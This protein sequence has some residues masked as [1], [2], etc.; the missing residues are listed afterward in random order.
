MANSTN[1]AGVSFAP[2]S[3][4]SSCRLRFLQD[5]SSQTNLFGYTDAPHDRTTGDIT[6]ATISFYPNAVLTDGT[7]TQ[8][9]YDPSAPGYDTIYQRVAVHE[10][11]H[12]M[13]LE[14]PAPDPSNPCHVQMPGG[15]VMNTFRGTNDQ[16]NNVP[17][18]PTPCDNDVVKNQVYGSQTANGSSGGS[19]SSPSSYFCTYFYTYD[20][21]YRCSEGTCYE[22]YTVYWYTGSS[23]N[24]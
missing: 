1:G 22:Q 3:S 23:C 2:A 19:Y 17:L 12:T 10:M 11:G 15:S 4:S 14:H 9:A 8:P 20:T 16:C 24:Y 5:T 6:S 13:G 18:K 21:W 7:I